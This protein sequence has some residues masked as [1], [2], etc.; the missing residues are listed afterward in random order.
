MWTTPNSESVATIITATKWNVLVNDLR[1]LKGLDGPVQFDSDTSVVSSSGKANVFTT[2]TSAYGSAQLQ[3]GDSSNVVRAQI[4][5]QRNGTGSGGFLIVFTKNSAGTL[6]EAFR[7]DDA[8][9][10]GIGTTAPIK[11]LH[12][13]DGVGGMMFGSVTN[14]TT[15]DVTLLPAGGFTNIVTFYCNCR[16]SDQN[17]SSTFFNGPQPINLRRGDYGDIFTQ[18]S[19]PSYT[20]ELRLIA[21]TDGSVVA[22]RMVGTHSWSIAFLAL[23]L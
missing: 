9:N 4:W 2:T 18:G 15:S 13:V 20:E 12:V 21:G 5:S 1:Y 8:Q 10:V 19:Y 23:V 11:H 7:V 17:A 22:R 6:T 3:L 16:S 14:V